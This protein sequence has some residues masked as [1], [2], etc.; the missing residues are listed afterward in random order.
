MGTAGHF[1]YY[2]VGSGRCWGCGEG[3]D[4]DGCEGSGVRAWGERRT[5]AVSNIALLYIV[6]TV[7]VEMRVGV[8]MGGSRGGGRSIAYWGGVRGIGSTSRGGVTG[9][10][11]I[12]TGD[13]R[14]LW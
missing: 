6:G 13:E 3:L 9:T 14:P 1:R 7:E 8:L 5:R 11:R 2:Y 4:G 12:N 10:L